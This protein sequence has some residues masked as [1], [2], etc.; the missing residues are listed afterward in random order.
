MNH[1]IQEHSSE[2]LLS[3]VEMI[4]YKESLINDMKSI[5]PPGINAVP[6]TPTTNNNNR[7][8]NKDARH[9]SIPSKDATTKKSHETVNDMEPTNND[10]EDESIELDYAET[11]DEQEKKEDKHRS[12][13]VQRNINALHVALSKSA[14]YDSDHGMVFAADSRQNSHNNNGHQLP[15][16]PLRG[17][18]R[19]GSLSTANGLI[20]FPKSVPKSAIITNTSL[21]FLYDIPGVEI[22]PTRRGT[23]VD[24]KVVD[25][26]ALIRHVSTPSSNHTHAIWQQKRSSTLKKS[27]ISV[28]M[29]GMTQIGNESLSIAN[30]ENIGIESEMGLIERKKPLKNKGQKK[31]NKKSLKSMVLSRSEGEIIEEWK[32][33]SYM[34]YYKYIAVGAEFEINIDYGTRNKLIQQMHDINKWLLN[35]EINLHDLSIVFDNCIHQ[36]YQFCKFSMGRFKQS[37]EFET[38]V[39][40]FDIQAHEEEVPALMITPVSP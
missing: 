10:P 2:C 40:C 11:E 23:S 31:L 32:I 17:R 14:S 8:N 24:P 27:Q 7:N 5:Q 34:L 6:S 16:T 36:M 20:D 22:S 13:A 39:R 18:G 30:I 29:G 25:K 28:E 9:L 15:T 1:L 19:S 37:D 12:S 3:L 26:S 33:R 4:Q 35:E 21:N 38:L